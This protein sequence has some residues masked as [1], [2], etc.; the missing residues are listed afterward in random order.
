M[1]ILSQPSINPIAVSLGFIH[2]Y[3][4][5]L[6]YTFAFI[7]A[8][9]VGEKKLKKNTFME[10]DDFYK[11][12]LYCIIGVVIGG[13]LGYFLFYDIGKLGDF[14]L[15]ENG[16]MSFHGGLLG[17]IIAVFIYSI[18]NK[19]NFLR[20]TDF[21]V[22]LVPFGLGAGRLG[23]FIN[24][25]LW[26][27]VSDSYGGMIFSKAKEMDYTYAIN[28]PKLMEIF[29]KYNGLPRYPSQLLE[30]F[31]EG[32]VLFIIISVYSKKERKK[33]R[34]SGLFL[35]C[36]GLFRIFIEFFREPDE[37]LGF[38]FNEISMGQLLSLPLLFVGLYL[39]TRNITE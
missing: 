30:L 3:W 24:G 5:G 6:M 36:Y 23:N 29:Y 21:I 34:I 1:I 18:R 13:R 33:G 38:L 19:K 7:F 17:V 8:L 27:R 31:L 4:Y 14:L 28:H 2:I 20:T 10:K 11:L 15:F 9:Y 16:G 25:E 12:I 22:P 32:I 37:Q 35:L 39:L 26:G